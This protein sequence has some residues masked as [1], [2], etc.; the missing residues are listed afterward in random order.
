MP[1]GTLA[2]V[3]MVERNFAPLALGTAFGLVGGRDSNHYQRGYLIHCG[4][5]MLLY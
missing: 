4:G 2:Q 3:P 1:I 5:S